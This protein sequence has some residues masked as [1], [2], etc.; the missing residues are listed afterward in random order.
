MGHDASMLRPKVSH[1]LDYEG[2][3]TVI[4]G[5]G[6]RYIPAENALDHVA[7]YTIANDGTV[8]NF[9]F[10]TSQ[11]TMGKNFDGTGALGPFLVTADEVAAGDKGLLLETRLNSEVVQRAST[12]EM[13]YNVATCVSFVSQGITLEPGDAI[14]MGTPSGIGYK[15]NPRLFMRSGDLVE[16]KIE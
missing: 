15:R 1:E 6:W 5:K 2:E 9:Q 14:M 7:G 8:R 13:I 16:V 4:I 11:W 10:D 3:L 12:S